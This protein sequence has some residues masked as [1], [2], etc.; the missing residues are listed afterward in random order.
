MPL[1]APAPLRPATEWAARGLCMRIA[2]ARRS[3]PFAREQAELKRDA[4][5]LHHPSPRPFAGERT[6]YNHPHIER[7]DGPGA[8]TPW[9]FALE[10]LHDGQALAPLEPCSSSGAKVRQSSNVRKAVP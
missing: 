2:T 1:A 5:A 3:F 10:L 7:S 6:H 8:P 9:S 4:K